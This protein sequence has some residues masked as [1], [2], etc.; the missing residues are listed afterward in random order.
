MEYPGN[1]LWRA[2]TDGSEKLQLTP[3]GMLVVQ[4][5]WSPDGTTIA[6]SALKKGTPWRM[7]T[8]KAVGGT[9][10]P[11][12]IQTQSQLG[13]AWS[14]DGKSIIF[15][16]I[17]ARETKMLLHELNLETHALTDIPG[18]EGMW[19][20]TRSRDGR[21]VLAISV[22]EKVKLRMYDVATKSWTEVRQG[23][24]AD[25]GFY[26]D[27]KSIFYSDGEGQA[28]YRMRLSDRKIERIADVR[29]IDQPSLPYW[30]AWT[31]IA[32]DGSPLL[33]HDLGTREIYALELEK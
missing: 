19:L 9:P 1:A 7:Y 20:P 31:G 14:A 3:E 15:G 18:S 10:E 23:L 21:Y 5:R 33:M 28:M 26:P 29:H 6:F 30:P 8:V 24:L 22:D 13:P 11:I 25:F 32:P 12:L 17:L 2:R 4:P 27:G 16:Q